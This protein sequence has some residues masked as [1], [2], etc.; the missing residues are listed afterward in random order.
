LF[1]G[2]ANDLAIGDCASI[3]FDSDH[4]IA[5]IVS[6]FMNEGKQDNIS[7]GAGDDYAIG[8]TGDDWIWGENGTDVVVGDSA[9]ITFYENTPVAAGSLFWNVPKMIT[10][11]GCE[12]SGGDQ[13]FGG[14]GDV[15]YIIGGGEVRLLL[16]LFVCMM[17]RTTISHHYL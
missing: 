11:S 4:R 13:L 6:T 1:G 2:N 12:F 16:F 5:S 15:D 9:E 8:G 7:L 17:G 10:S 14:D 3:T